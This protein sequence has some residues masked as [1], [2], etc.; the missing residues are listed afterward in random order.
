MVLLLKGLVVRE[1]WGVFQLQVK[2]HPTQICQANNLKKTEKKPKRDR[3]KHCCGVMAETCLKNGKVVIYYEK[4]VR[5]ASV[6]PPCRV[7]RAP[8]E[9]E[10]NPQA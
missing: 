3:I 2:Y 7:T 8:D 10:S 1:M 9:P 6:P 4:S 5:F